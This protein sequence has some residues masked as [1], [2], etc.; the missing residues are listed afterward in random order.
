M[1]R[2]SWTLGWV[3]FKSPFD[4]ISIFGLALSC[5]ELPIVTVSSILTE[6]V[7]W[8]NHY[9]RSALG[10]PFG[11]TKS[12]GHGREHCIETLQEYTTAKSIRVPS[13]FGAIPNWRA[14]D[15]I[16]EQKN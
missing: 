2:E 5:L 9:W 15:E 12:S 1:F 16:F 10:T 8:I 11:G 6:F 3:C 7:V 13:G 4:N 14:V